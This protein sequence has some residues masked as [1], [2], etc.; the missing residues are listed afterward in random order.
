M[1]CP[2]PV[3]GADRL[4]AVFTDRTRIRVPV[5]IGRKW[6]RVAV[7][8]GAL[9]RGRPPLRF[10]LGLGSGIG[11]GVPG[12]RAQVGRSE[13]SSAPES[14][15]RCRNDCSGQLGTGARIG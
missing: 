9:E 15:L 3:N 5:D 2:T 8:D 11:A 12:I 7:L 13:R 6:R 4:A 10:G 1:V 14:V